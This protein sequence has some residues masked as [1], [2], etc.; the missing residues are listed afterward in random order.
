MFLRVWQ[1]NKKG[2][3]KFHSIH[4]YILYL[5]TL[6]YM[7]ILLIQNIKNKHLNGSLILRKSKFKYHLGLFLFKEK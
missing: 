1:E 7:V 4:V 6:K 2:F 3:P 5:K